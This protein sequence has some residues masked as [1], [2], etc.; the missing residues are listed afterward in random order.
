MS[1]SSDAVQRPEISYLCVPLLLA[2]PVGYVLAGDEGHWW[3]SEI[4]GRDCVPHEA[5]DN[6]TQVLVPGP[7]YVPHGTYGWLGWLA[8]LAFVAGL[9]LLVAAIPRVIRRTFP[10]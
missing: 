7:D 10:D 8:V 9:M 4:V 2:G 1:E 3:A 6:C 5:G